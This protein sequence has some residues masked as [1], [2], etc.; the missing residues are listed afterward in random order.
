VLL[1]A[2]V[3]LGWA[4]LLATIVAGFTYGEMRVNPNLDIASA[5]TLKYV[6]DIGSVVF[7]ILQGAFALMVVAVG[8]L[9]CSR[10][11]FVLRIVALAFVTSGICY[12]LVLATLSN[13]GAPDP[14][15]T[16]AHA[17]AEWLQRIGAHLR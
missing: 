9:R 12:G 17:L 7:A 10:V 14:I 1:S 11:Q 3:A 15:E 2:D 6:S 8:F 13:G 4:L 5:L 16:M